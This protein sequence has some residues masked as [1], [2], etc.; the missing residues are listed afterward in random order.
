M[1]LKTLKRL[2]RAAGHL[3]IAVSRPLAKT[4]GMVLRRDH[5]S[6][7][8]PRMVVIKLLG[9]GSLIVA[10]PSLLALRQRYPHTRMTLVCTPGVKP[11]AELMHVFDEILIVDT[12]SF[13]ALTRTTTKAL[14]QTFLADNVVD[15][16]IHSKLSAVFSLLTCARNRIGFFLDASRWRLGLGTHFLFLNPSSLVATGYNQI[17]A[18]F[19]CR[20]N[21]SDTAAWFRAHNELRLP[22][23]QHQ[24][25]RTVVLAPYC[26][27]LGRERELSPK[28]W[29]SVFAQ[30]SDMT[31]TSLILLGDR[32]RH[33]DGQDLANSLASTLVECEVVNLIGQTDLRDLPA[34]LG[35]ADEVVTI[36]SGINHLARLCSRKVTSYWGPTDPSTRLSPIE[37]LDE[38]TH[39]RKIFCSPCVHVVDDAPCQGNN[40]C[41]QQH[42]TAIDMASFEARGWSVDRDTSLL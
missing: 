24:F 8:G 26:S 38:K 40:I 23:G 22:T 11:F 5:S 28:A 30:K 42:A 34:I 4:L 36:D 17:A 7:M 33:L 37:G 29:V 9:G 19:D 10:M 18:L 39:Y 13:L 27:E 25:S 41:M 15:L 35:S 6:S 31:R 21:M 1:K 3:L 16:E 32:S 14:R 20:V 2:D 12:S